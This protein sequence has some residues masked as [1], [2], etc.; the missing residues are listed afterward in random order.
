MQLTRGDEV[1]S[2][3]RGDVLTVRALS[4]LSGDMMLAGLGR[5]VLDRLVPDEEGGADVEARSIALFDGVLQQLASPALPD[6]TGR[7]RLERRFVR[8][9][10]GW[11]CRIDLPA[12]DGGHAH[13]TFADIAALIEASR[14]EPEAA[15]L[16][17]AAFTLLAGAEGRVHGISPAEVRFH[18]VGALDSILDICL[19]CALFVRLAPARFICSP[20]PMGDGQIHCAHGWIPAP[21]PAV[22]ELLPGVPVHAF[23]GRGETVTPTAIA[24]LKTLGAEFGP[25]PSMTVRERALVYGTHVFDDVCNGAIWASGPATAAR[26]GHGGAAGACHGHARHDHHNPHA[27]KGHPHAHDGDGA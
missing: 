16:A 6:F 1:R 12:E 15:R 19:A 25:W 22:L 8:N 17:L 26:C 10:A 3:R 7:V 13:R 9:V 14:L 18:E 20:L 24:L 27:G 23:A 4:G 5:L 11:G 21:A 2:D